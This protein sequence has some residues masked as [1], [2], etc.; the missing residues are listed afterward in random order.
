MDTNIDIMKRFFLF[1]ALLVAALAMSCSPEDVNNGEGTP[2]DGTENPGGSDENGTLSLT[3]EGIMYFSQE[4]GDGV[5]NYTL[6]GA[7]EDA[8][9]AAV[10]EADWV[11]I[12]EVGNEIKF[13]V[14]PNDLTKERM[15][16]ILL[17]YAK[18]SAQV[19][20][21][22]Q[23]KPNVEFYASKINGKFEKKDATHPNA[24]KYTV[25]LSKYGTT[26]DTDY[27]PD[28][29]YYKFIIYSSVPAAA[30]PYLAWGEYAYD[31]DNTY[32]E[33]TFADDRSELVITDKEG[34]Q[35]MHKIKGGSVVVSDNKVEALITLDN[36]ELHK[37]TYSGSLNLYYFSSIDRGPYSTIEED[38]TFDIKDG[39][40]M[41]LYDGDYYGI[42]RGSWEIRFM[43]RADYMAGDFFRFDVVAESSEYDSE[44][45]YRTFTA[46]AGSTYA[47][48]TFEPGY[49]MDGD[50]YGSW[51]MPVSEGYFGSV[52]AALAGGSFTVE[53]YG[54]EEALV[55]FEVVDDRGKKLSGKCHCKYIEEYDR[56]SM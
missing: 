1:M 5:I 9:V 19:V 29:S 26:R 32:A 34:K 13:T 11:T 49:K 16:M 48:G 27:Y 39:A 44:L 24:Y 36:G 25:I 2:N 56:T 46:D 35:T 20:V 37:V 18:Q 10:C 55:T 41:L 30:D 14:A 28:D 40:M 47:A 51:Y 31:A 6:V 38:F 53:H 4:G 7:S 21:E 17:S 23:G 43:T 52:A 8:T 3:S 45:V 54:D 33:G 22:Q 50:L 12:T 15:A 42:G